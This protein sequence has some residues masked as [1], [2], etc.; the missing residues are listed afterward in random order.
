MRVAMSDGGYSDVCGSFTY[1]EVEDYTV[2]ITAMS[3]TA[4]APISNENSG[5]R[6]GENDENEVA[7]NI[8]AFP[9]PAKDK[10]S[11]KISFDNTKAK[12]I[13]FTTGAIVKEFVLNRNENIIDISDLVNG[14]YILSV[15]GEK[16]PLTEVFIKQ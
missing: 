10:L 5:N 15:E 2:N 13:N 12:I 6:L 8:K 14:I 1:A 4:F 7:A 11:V 16:A 9:N 3:A